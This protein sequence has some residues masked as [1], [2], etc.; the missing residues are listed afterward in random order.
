VVYAPLR[1]IR[2]AI[3]GDA[4]SIDVREPHAVEAV[5]PTD[6]AN[7]L[8]PLHRWVGLG[9]LV[10]FLVS[11]QYMRFHQP[12]MPELDPGPHLMFTSR[13][14][15]MLAAALVNITLGAYVVRATGRRRRWVQALGSALLVLSAVLLIAAFVFEPMSGRGRTA[16]SSY[17]LY[18]LFAGALLHFAA[19]LRTST[20]T[21]PG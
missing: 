11:G 17:G 21:P 6:S 18:S 10:V 12:P 2:G 19:S 15:Y 3:R 5:S 7:R 20:R 8:A 4:L 13:H 14:I 9:T 16:V 1:A